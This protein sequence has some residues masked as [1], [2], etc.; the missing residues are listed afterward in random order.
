MTDT[1]VLDVM[2]VGAGISGINAAYRVQSGLP[3]AS[4]A[5]I[6]ARDRIGGTWDFFKYPGLRSD[7]DLSTFGFTWRPWYSSKMIADGE[8]IRSYVETCA[9]EFGIDKHINFGHRLISADWSDNKW[10]LTVEA[11]GQRKYF[12]AKFI[13]LATGYYD[14][15]TPLK[16]DIPGIENFQGTIAHPQ[17]WP[18]DMNVKGKKLVIIGSGATAIT[19]LPVLVDQGADVTLLQ[20]SPSYVLSRPSVDGFTRLLTKILPMQLAAFFARIKF[21]VLPW[22]FYKFCRAYPGLAKKMIRRE[23]AK[24]LPPS[25][26]VDPHFLPRYDP[27]DQRLCLCPDQDFFKALKT[28][29][30]HMATGTIETVTKNGIEYHPALPTS[31]PGD[32]KKANA[33][34][35]G[36][37][38]GHLPA[39]HTTTIDAD[40]IVTA[41]GLKF[42]LAG[43]A[44]LTVNGQPRAISDSYIW[45]GL[46]LSDIPNAATIIGYTNASWTLGSDSSAK[47]IV[48]LLKH[49]RK[50]GTSV[51]VPRISESEAKSMR[52]MDVV[53]LNSTYVERARG[54]M[55]KAGDVAPWRP[56]SSYWVDM[57]QAWVGGW[58]GLQFW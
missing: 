46:L 37:A 11:D 48:R 6:E 1:K 35:N 38:D 28:G 4:Y 34:A 5:L 30:A 29:N 12:Q 41:T 3:D 33:Q 56:R 57:W 20:R 52:Q 14:Y 2:V 22:I 51:A 54:D 21:L 8:S 13:V 17:F 16:T 49:M 10:T 24:Q 45:K 18:T 26:P 53:N 40:I 47:T 9:R 43:G 31:I 7:S 42:L 55:P 15:K 32:Y 23:T 50:N 58:E 39:K 36:F 25:I 19:L 44:D 27:W